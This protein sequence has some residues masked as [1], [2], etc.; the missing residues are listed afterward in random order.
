[1]TDVKEPGLRERKR[2]ATRH[3]IERAAIELSLEKGYENVTV[4][5]IAEQ[6][7]VSPRTFFNYFSSKE[8]AVVGHH[9]E[10]PD[11]EKVE[12]FLAAPVDQPVL[13]GIHQMLSSFIEAKSDED[14][15][16]VHELQERRMQLMLRHPTLFRQR[17]EGMD[18]MTNKMTEIVARRLRVL[19]PALDEAPARDRARLVVF[20]S[21]A[22]MRHAWANWADHGGEG[23]LAECVKSSFDQLHVLSSQVN[24]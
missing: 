10:G 16:A 15:R 3:A 9:P 18:E 1:M 4:D 24:V 11:A 5:E 12:A 19:D 21:F 23:R 17:M 14:T 8:A 2:V 20:V 7:D 13:A 22:G 6:A